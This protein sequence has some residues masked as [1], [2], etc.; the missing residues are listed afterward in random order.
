MIYYSQEIE[1]QKPIIVFKK[2]LVVNDLT[3]KKVV[4]V[5]NYF[6]NFLS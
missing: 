3:F 5:I 4:L 1:T 6:D 2:P